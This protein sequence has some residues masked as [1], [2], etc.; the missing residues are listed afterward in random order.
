MSKRADIYRKGL[1][2]FF[3]FAENYISQQP[4]PS[5]EEIDAEWKAIEGLRSI[6]YEVMA[7]VT[8]LKSPTGFIVLIGEEYI[9]YDD[10]LPSLIRICLLPEE[11][12]T[13]K[14]INRRMAMMPIE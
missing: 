2:R 14:E 9:R 7:P 11:L 13:P 6:P 5:L 4:S 10:V 1:D 3:Q 8:S 12:D